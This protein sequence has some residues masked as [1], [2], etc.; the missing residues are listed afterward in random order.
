[1]IRLQAINAVSDPQGERGRNYYE[2]ATYA[3]QT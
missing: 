3:R 2:N 1:M